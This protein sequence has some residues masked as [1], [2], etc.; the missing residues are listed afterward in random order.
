[1]RCLRGVYLVHHM[2]WSLVDGEI[3]IGEEQPL[4]NL[5]CIFVT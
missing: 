4:D 5:L 3:T 2:Q 1:M